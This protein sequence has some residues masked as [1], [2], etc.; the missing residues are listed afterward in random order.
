MKNYQIL[1]FVA[2]AIIGLQSCGNTDRSNRD[3]PGTNK[4]DTSLDTTMR[5]QVGTSDVDLSGDEKTFLLNA[6]TGGMVEVA[7]SE[8]IL[9]KTKNAAVKQFAE[10]MVKDHTKVGAELAGI[11]KTKGI[12]LPGQLADSKKNELDKMK[13]LTGD[14]LDKKYIVMMINDHKQ[15]IDW[16]DRATTYSNS[17]IRQFAVNTLP[18]LKEHAKMADEIGKKLNV[19]NAGNGDNL[20]NVNPDTKAVPTTTKTTPK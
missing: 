1:P 3:N 20:S 7:A 6:G 12:T 9:P 15:T 8:L 5:A 10:M 18:A 19:S 4:A 11:A 17:N 14:E 2:M 16:F 13:Q